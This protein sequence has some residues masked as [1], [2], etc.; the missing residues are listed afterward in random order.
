MSLFSRQ[1]K[2]EERS[3]QRVGVGDGGSWRE[4]IRS[5]T[6]TGR[7]EPADEQPT[8]QKRGGGLNAQLVT[9]ETKNLAKLPALMS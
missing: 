7:R 1:E 2:Q 5:K 4:N 3:R 8:L 9:T 6:E